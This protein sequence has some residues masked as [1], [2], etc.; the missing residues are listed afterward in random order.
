[1]YNTTG[2]PGSTD[3]TSTRT[4]RITPADCQRL[5]AAYD[6]FGVVNGSRCL[7][8]TSLRQ[9][10]VAPWVETIICDSE[11]GCMVPE[12]AAPKCDSKSSMQLYA[13]NK[14]VPQLAPVSG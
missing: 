8:F 6:F 13:R 14:P 7:G 11:A 4:G 9:A 3:L 1:V 12:A 10:A 2:H 5:A